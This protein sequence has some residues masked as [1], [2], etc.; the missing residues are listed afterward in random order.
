MI[1]FERHKDIDLEQVNGILKNTLSETLGMEVTSISASTLIMKM[2]VD[3][4]TV[5][6]FKVLNGGASMALAESAA[7]LGANMIAEEGFYCVGMEIN[8][9]HLR[10]VSSGYVHAH[11]SPVYIGKKSQVWEIR[12][13]DDQEKLICVSRMTLAV[14]QKPA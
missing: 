6:P 7:S 8:G 9:N 5:Q 14:L 12:I 2:P 4:R 3:H 11:A 13:L 1:V 10:P